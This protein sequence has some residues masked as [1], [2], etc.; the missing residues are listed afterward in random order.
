M[1]VLGARGRSDTPVSDD[2]L[3]I[4]SIS[5]QIATASLAAGLSDE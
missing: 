2:A 1:Y 4:V 5:M 3:A